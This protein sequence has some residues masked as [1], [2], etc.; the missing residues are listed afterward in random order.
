MWDPNYIL[1]LVKDRDWRLGACAD[2]GHW[3]R[4]DLTLNYGARYDTFDV[5][6]DNE[7]QISLRANVVWEINNATTAHEGYARYFMPPTLEYVA[8]GVVKEFDYTTD[9]PFN[10]RDDPQK[11]VRDNYFDAGLSRQITPAWQ[12]TGD[13][14]CKLA[15][16]LLDDGQFGTAVILNNFNYS[17]GTVYGAE[18]GS[19][20]KSG[21]FSAYGN[22]SH[23]Q[24]WAQNFDSVENEFPDNE[25]AYLVEHPFQLDHQGRFTGS[26]G[27]CYTFPK[28]TR[29][30]SDFLYGDGL[31]AGF[32]NLEKLPAYWTDNVGVEHVWHLHSSG[33]EHVETAF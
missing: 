29:L 9:A 4:S 14:F 22:F 30:Y 16:N 26:G 15:K 27:F 33:P 10:N 21:P 12:I 25:S 3:V 24:T 19:A 18:L 17:K 6:F 31:R 23:V 13:T 11:V 32:A 8:P 20:Y 1:S 5:S 28:D 7:W 2:T